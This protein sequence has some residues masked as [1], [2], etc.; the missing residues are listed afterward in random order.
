MDAFE[1][2]W[3]ESAFSVFHKG[4]LGKAATLGWG[5]GVGTAHVEEVGGAVIEG[6]VYFSG[7][8][9]DDAGVCDG[10]GSPRRVVGGGVVDGLGDEFV[11]GFAGFHEAVAEVG[12]LVEFVG[13]AG[14]A[15]DV[16][17]VAFGELFG[18]PTAGGGEGGFEDDLGGTAS[19]VENGCCGGF[20]RAADFAK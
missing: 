19:E 12:M 8:A 13:L 2:A 20:V 14:G 15:K 11:D 17:M 1:G 9:R 16:F 7:H 18:H 6:D 3:G 4:F 10:V 5:G